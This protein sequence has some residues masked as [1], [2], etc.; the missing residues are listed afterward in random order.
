MK[1]IVAR[2]ERGIG[3][4]SEEVF[5]ARRVVLLTLNRDS[6]FFRQTPLAHKTGINKKP[7]ALGYRRI[8]DVVD[9]GSTASTMTIKF[10]F[11]N[12][13]PNTGN[14]YLQVDGHRPTLRL[15]VTS[16]LFK[17]EQTE[18]AILEWKRFV[19]KYLK[20]TNKKTLPL[21]GSLCFTKYKGCQHKRTVCKCRVS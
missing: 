6:S 18:Q 21:V 3:C 14:M 7:L 17:P 9:Q 10:R 16:I 5:A 8:L 13:N 4:C 19:F 12:A 20:T 11:G 2:K 15:N 1:S